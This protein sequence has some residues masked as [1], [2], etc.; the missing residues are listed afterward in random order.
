M[1]VFMERGVGGELMNGWGPHA[2]MRAFIINGE[3]ERD[4]IGDQH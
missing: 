4:N 1:C 3:R 2:V